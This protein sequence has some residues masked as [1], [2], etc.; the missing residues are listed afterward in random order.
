MRLIIAI[1]VIVTLTGCRRGVESHPPKSVNTSEI[2]LNLKLKESTKT[3]TPLEIYI[4]GA[5][6]DPEE[7]KKSLISLTDN[8]I[9]ARNRLPMEYDIPEWGVASR[10]VYCAT[11]S[12]EWLREA[13]NIIMATLRKERQSV[14]DG[15]G[16]VHGLSTHLSEGYPDWLNEADKV[17]LTSLYVNAFHQLTLETSAEMA[18]LLGLA[19]DMPMKFEAKQVKDNLNRRFWSAPDRHYGQY[20]YSTPY[21][22][23][24]KG[25]DYAANAVCIIGGITTAEMSD[26]TI[27]SLPALPGGFPDTYPLSETSTSYSASVQAL[28]ALA[29]AKTRNTEAFKAALE[30]LWRLNGGDSILWQGVLLR[31]IFGLNMTPEGISVSPF[32]PEGFT[33]SVRLD[34]LKYRDM[35]L[36]MSIHGSGDRIASFAIDSVNGDPFI[37][38]TLTGHHDVEIVMANNTMADQRLARLTPDEILSTP[39]EGRGNIAGYNIYINGILEIE[40]AARPPEPNGNDVISSV[41]MNEDGIEGVAGRPMFNQSATEFVTVNATAITPRRPPLHLIKNRETATHYIELAP[42]HNTRLTFY[43]TLPEAGR[44][45]VR[46]YYSNGTDKTALRTLG[47]IHSTDSTRVDTPVGTLVCPP[48]TPGDWIKT[49]PSTWLEAELEAG[50]NHLSLTYINGTILFNRIEFLKK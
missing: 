14:I 35:T 20:L 15:D 5:L 31:S 44:Y 9:I 1:V 13:Y 36:S 48:V 30:S 26:L 3:M 18:T 42:R 45:F 41:P 21:P 11:G 40:K 28:I 29:A 38:A 12:G 39:M 27:T 25:T 4:G 17:S 23:L 43:A 7:A 49:E 8:G 34:S 24:S 22:I 10:E 32:I 16:M 6:I 50:V 19:A 33:S 47:V 37:P 46:I 2:D